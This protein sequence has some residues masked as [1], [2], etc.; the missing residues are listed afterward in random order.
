MGMRDE[1]RRGEERRMKSIS[2]RLR[3]L[4]GVCVCVCLE[5]AEFLRG[6]LPDFFS[7]YSMKKNKL[8]RLVRRKLQTAVK[9]ISRRMI[10]RIE[11][12]DLLKQITAWV[13][14]ASVQDLRKL[15]E[16]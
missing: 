3:P 7:H 6:I 12:S 2:C 5:G 13:S 15:P 11:M 14:K 4:C 1:E 16:K 9:R 10:R 8:Q